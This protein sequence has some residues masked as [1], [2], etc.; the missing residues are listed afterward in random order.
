MKNDAGSEG[1]MM[2]E[3]FEKELKHRMKG[4]RPADRK[5]MEA[6]KAHWK[7]V[8]KPL[9]SLGKLED[10]VIRMAGIKGT[11][12]YTTGKKGLVIM[13][14]DNGVVA[15]GVTQT[16]QEVTAIVAENFTRRATSVCLMAEIAGADL[17]PVDI[18]M[19]SDVPAVTKTEYKVM[20]GTKDMLYE[21]AMTREQAARAVLTGIHMAEKLAGQGYG[22]LAT[23]EMGIGNTTT[24]S[25]VA[26]VLL[27]KDAAEVTGRGAGL[28]AEGL[29]RKVDVIRRSIELHQPDKEDVLDV[30]SKVGGLDI[31]GLAGVFLGGALY[32][33]PVIIDGFIS[34]VAALCAARMC[35]AAAD[36]MMPSHKSGE[37]AG[38]MVLDALELSPFIDCNMSLG[39]GSGAVAAIPLLEMGLSVYREMSTFDEIHVEQYEDFNE[40]MKRE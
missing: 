11:A 13:C 3:G 38:G 10:A 5:S 35:P 34:S 17:F 22:L 26:A 21:P 36:C 25:A 12:D 23:G 20:S 18:G 19:A 37:P 39:E 7:T 27:E 31:A 2:A 8:G 9:Y 40:E 29:D 4:I 28:S 24:S 14:A 1:V 6:A 15:E 33:I 16:G 32:H 30:L